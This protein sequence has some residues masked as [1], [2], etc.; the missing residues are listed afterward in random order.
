MFSLTD[1]RLSTEGGMDTVYDVLNEYM[2]GSLFTSQ[3]PGA[4]A[5]LKKNN[6]T[7][8]AKACEDLKE[9]KAKA[10]TDDFEKL[11]DYIERNHKAGPFYHVIPTS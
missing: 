4:Y 11:M 7:W 1:G 9:I 3:L 6:P 2:G 8:F 10:G 5:L